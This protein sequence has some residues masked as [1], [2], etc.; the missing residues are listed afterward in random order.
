MSRRNFSA[1]LL[2]APLLFIHITKLFHSHDWSKSSS[3]AI[4][5][6]TTDLIAEKHASFSCTICDYQLNK[7]VDINKASIECTEVYIYKILNS[8]VEK[9]GF[10]SYRLTRSDRGPPAFLI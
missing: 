8:S 7:D 3:S 9:S 1:I 2:L 5:G 6:I 4:S 10:Y